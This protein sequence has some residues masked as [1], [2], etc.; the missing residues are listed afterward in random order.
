MTTATAIKH[1][2]VLGKE[3][4]YVKLQNGEHTHIINVGEGTYKKVKDLESK[5]PTGELP[6]DNQMED[7]VIIAPKNKK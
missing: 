2:D 4:F 5:S 3:L 7:S 1:A 6:L